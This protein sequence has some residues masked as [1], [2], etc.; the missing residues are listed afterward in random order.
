MFAYSSRSDKL[1]FTK[2]GMLI[3]LDQE[4]NIG[5]PKTLEKVSRVWVPVRVVPVA[6]KLNTIEQR[7]DQ[8]CL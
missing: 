5:K 2:L 1:I 3:P 8:S 4:E 7:Q 6:W